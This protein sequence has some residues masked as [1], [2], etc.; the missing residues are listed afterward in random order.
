MHQTIPSFETYGPGSFMNEEYMDIPTDSRCILSL[1]AKSTPGFTQSQDSLSTMTSE[2]GSDP[3]TPGP[4]KATAV[5]AALHALC[6]IV[7]NEILEE[8]DGKDNNRQVRINTDH[9]AFWLSTVG[10]FQWNRMNIKAIVDAGKMKE[11]FKVDFEKGA[12]G[13]SL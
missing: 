10:L 8:R 5:A 3:I 13:I 11:F 1:I 2:G 12:S 6:G 9:T 7:A 4:I